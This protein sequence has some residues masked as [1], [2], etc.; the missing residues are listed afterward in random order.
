MQLIVKPYHKNSYPRGGILVSGSHVS[1]WLQQIQRMDLS[2][3]ELDVYPVAGMVANTI[4][5]C[6]L[7][8]QRDGIWPADIGNNVYCQCIQEK[9]FLPEN[10]RLYPQLSG[11]E[12][13]KV[14]KDKPHLFHPETGWVELPEPLR[15]KD[16][17]IH[18]DMAD[19]A[20]S[21]ERRVGKEC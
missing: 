4:W 11:K 2:L 3:E 10:S 7:V 21:E 20:R 17:L 1:G 12:L 18:P 19:R 15:W 9:L 13:D 5:G 16:Q 14:L 6:L 8:P